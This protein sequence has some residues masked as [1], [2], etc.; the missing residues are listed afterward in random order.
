MIMRKLLLVFC[1][2]LFLSAAPAMAAMFGPG[3]GASLQ[4]VFDDITVNP[5]TGDDPSDAFDSWVT[6]TADDEI[7]DDLDSYW[8][9]AAGGNSSASLIIEMAGYSASNKFG[10][11]DKANPANKLQ[12]FDGAADSAATATM[13]VFASGIF[14]LNHNGATNVLFGGTTFGYYLDSPDGVFYSDTSLNPDSQ[15]H[16]YAWQ[17]NDSDWVSIVD[18]E[19][20]LTSLAPGVWEDNEYILAFEDLFGAGLPSSDRDFTDFVVMVESVNPVPVPGAILLGMLGLGA[21]GIKLR[22]FA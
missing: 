8:A 5:A 21:V 9:V 19:N 6:V 10:V 15:D 17:G 4:D 1:L 2:S 13:T 7:A 16:M 20:P 14:Q 22:K 3:G 12:I 18:H 11:Y